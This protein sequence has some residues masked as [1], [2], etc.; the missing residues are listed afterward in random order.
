MPSSG[1][2][3]A[4]DNVRHRF[5]DEYVSFSHLDSDRLSS[6]SDKGAGV[7]RMLDAIDGRETTC[8]K[9]SKLALD[10]CETMAPSAMETLRLVLKNGKNRKESICELMK[11]RRNGKP[12]RRSTTA[13]L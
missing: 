11:I 1:N 2:S 3:P 12:H 10:F 7:N 8:R 13:L 6:L 9:M 4:T 5:W